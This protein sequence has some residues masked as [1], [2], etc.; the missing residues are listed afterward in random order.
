MS[1]EVY[2][3]V[4]RGNFEEFDRLVAA[5]ASRRSLTEREQWN[6]LHQAL[7]L[8]HRSPPVAMIERLIGWGVDVNAVDCYGNTPL[9]YAV[10]QKTPEAESIVKLLVAAGAKVNVLNLD[11]GSALR[12]AISKLPINTQIVRALLNAGADMH[13]RPAD[14]RSV[15]EMIELIP[16]ASPE[17]RNL[18]AD[19]AGH[20]V[21]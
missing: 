15:K 18:F 12:Q 2:R 14:G 16:S 4:I 6:L 5:G 13:E 19:P 21:H 8:P 20:R 1:D 7:M 11:G 17:L 3:A 9:H 10:P